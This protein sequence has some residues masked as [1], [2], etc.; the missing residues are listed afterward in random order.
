VHHFNVG[1][2]V[3]ILQ[4]FISLYPSDH[5]FVVAVKLDPYREAFNEYTVRFS[6][7]S[8]ADLFECQLTDVATKRED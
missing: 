2:A 4:R 7:G 8:Q 1:D 6:D 3:S 5:G